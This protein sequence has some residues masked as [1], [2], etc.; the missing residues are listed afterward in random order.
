MS[1]NKPYHSDKLNAVAAGNSAF[2]IIGALLLVFVPF[3]DIGKICKD[4]VDRILIQNLAD[5]FYELLV[6]SGNKQS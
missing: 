4:A 3:A 2:K 5:T 6:M 1:V